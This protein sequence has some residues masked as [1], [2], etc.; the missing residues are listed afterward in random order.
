MRIKKKN[1]TSATIIDHILT[2]SNL[3]FFRMNKNV[4]VDVDDYDLDDGSTD[5]DTIMDNKKENEEKD[6]VKEDLCTI[7]KGADDIIEKNLDACTTIKDTC[8]TEKNTQKRRQK[9]KSSERNITINELKE[10][11]RYLEFNISKE[12]EFSVKEAEEYSNHELKSCIAEVYE[13]KV[14]IPNAKHDVHRPFQFMC[15]PT[16]DMKDATTKQSFQ[17]KR[18]KTI[19]H[20]YGH[21]FE[22]NIKINLMLIQVYKIKDPYHRS[23]N[24]EDFPL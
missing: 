3:K 9:R 22:E 7:K 4:G 14:C 5:K 15:N 23:F 13:R 19:Q 2:Q 11:G 1:D 10:G 18:K 17:Q 24:D 12:M 6:S 8:P 20:E 21:C 16:T